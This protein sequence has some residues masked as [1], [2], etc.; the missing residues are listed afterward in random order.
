MG[1][2]SMRKLTSLSYVDQQKV[3]ISKKRELWNQIYMAIF[4]YS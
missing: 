3:I 2:I 4:V 1:K